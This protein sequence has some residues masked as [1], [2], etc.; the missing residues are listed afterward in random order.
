MN[1][2]TTFDKKNVPVKR[3]QSEKHDEPTE[4]E[5]QIAMQADQD[6]END[7]ET[8]DPNIT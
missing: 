5:K 8:D 4:K 6:E 7:N 2:R 3:T 1:Y